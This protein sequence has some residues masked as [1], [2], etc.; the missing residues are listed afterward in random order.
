MILNKYLKLLIL[1]FSI[2]LLQ[3][4][5]TTTKEVKKVHGDL[6]LIDSKKVIEDGR[7]DMDKKVSEGPKPYDTEFTTRPENNFSE[8]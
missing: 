2:I 4:C 5:T 1:L 6:P 7:K 3:S 8:L